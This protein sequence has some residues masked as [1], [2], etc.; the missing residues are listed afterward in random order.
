MSEREV[1]ISLKGD[2]PSRRDRLR[3]W[4][5]EGD[6]KP[7]SSLYMTLLFLTCTKDLF[8]MIQGDKTDDR[9][10][11]VSDLETAGKI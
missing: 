6:L 10:T 3:W 5:L 1:R 9:T 2:L 7:E 11:L 8:F 4:Y